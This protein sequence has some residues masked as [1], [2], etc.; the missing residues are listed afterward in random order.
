MSIRYIRHHAI[1][2]E[3]WDRAINNSIS[4]LV[5]AFSWYLDS[6][7]DK[8]WDALVYGDYEAVFPLPWK[9]KYFLKYIYQP[10]F[11][12]QLGLF[13]Q[14]GFSLTN[15]DF[16]KKIPKS[17]VLV[18][19]QLNLY[20]GNNSLEGRLKH[21]YRLELNAPYNELYSHFSQDVKNNLKKVEKSGIE[22][23]F[24]I[25]AGKVF[26]INRGAWGELN[27]GVRDH[28]YSQ[29]MENCKKA[30]ERKQLVTIGAMQGNEMIGAALLFKTDRYLFYILSGKTGSGRKSGVM[31][32][33]VDKIIHTYSGQSLILDFE[34]SEI[35]SVAYFYRKFG[36]VNFPYLHYKKYN[37]F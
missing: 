3:K 23:V 9:R 6:A 30:T 24:D 16:I 28:H 2:Y 12:Q 19:L 14:K 11:C 18:D 27:P 37:L 21:N 7:T 35:E 33:I 17:F 31:N 15:A 1:D 20:A 5:Y 26:D 22:F 4:P 10:F 25:P 13:S 32:G 34:G 29:L 8:Q 36:S